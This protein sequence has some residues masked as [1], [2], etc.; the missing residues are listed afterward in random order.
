MK[1]VLLSAALL[2]LALAAPASAQSVTG[3]GSFVVGPGSV[4]GGDEAT[5]HLS[6]GG[7]VLY[8]GVGA[9]AEVGFLGPAVAMNDGLGVV[10][11]NGIY[12]LRMPR[13]SARRVSPFVTGGY[14]MFFR[15]GHL[16]L[17]NV[18]GGIDWWLARRVG[19]RVEVRDQIWHESYSSPYYSF[20]NTTH[21]WNFRTGVVF[22]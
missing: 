6:G 12:H 4:S 1:P 5:L 10:S 15:D 7:E 13:E 20:S 21:F 11:L 22:R 14:T 2:S 9:L 8:K 3:L 17:W 16:N 19:L 18:G